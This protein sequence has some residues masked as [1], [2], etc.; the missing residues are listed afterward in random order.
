ME[1][2]SKID[3]ASK[4]IPALT[5]LCYVFGFIIY[6][7][8]LGYFGIVDV[9]IFSLNYITAGL[10]YI[11]VVSLVVLPIYYWTLDSTY[12][13]S[14]KKQYL[15]TFLFS[16]IMYVFYTIFFYPVYK[17]K[18]ASNEIKSFCLFLSFSLLTHLCLETIKDK[19]ISWGDA[20]T[21]LFGLGIGSLFV[22]GFTYKHIKRN[23]GGGEIYKKILILE[24]PING[25]LTLNKFNMTDTLYILH[26]SEKEIFFLN[27]S[28]VCGI[29][30]DLIIGQI[31]IKN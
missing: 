7:T 10:H 26:E 31:A 17:E 22:F 4:L 5:F 28:K 15:L 29:K 25:L 11:F 13:R 8:H 27:Q 1:N 20:P 30:K 3:A 24:K 14:R 6:N 18:L 23:L 2:H 9:E 21:W 16:T 19:R 12:N